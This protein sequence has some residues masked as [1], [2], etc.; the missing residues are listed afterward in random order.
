MQESRV[1]AGSRFRFHQSFGIG[2][3]QVVLLMGHIEKLQS[4]KLLLIGLLRLKNPVD[5]NGEM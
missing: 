3:K 1:E 4:L 2:M 5:K